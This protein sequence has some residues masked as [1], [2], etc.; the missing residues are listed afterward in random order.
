ME[1]GVCNTLK[2]SLKQDGVDVIDRLT[3]F[4]ELGI[5]VVEVSMND[6]Y[7]AILLDGPK[8]SGNGLAVEGGKL[9]DGFVHER[10]NICQFAVDNDLVV[11]S[12]G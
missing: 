8:C 10:N 11:L 7:V 4:L 9:H 6:V 5:I 2:V 12:V 3:S 1:G